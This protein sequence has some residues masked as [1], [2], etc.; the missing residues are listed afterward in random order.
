MGEQVKTTFRLARRRKIRR[1]F[2]C[3][4]LV[5]GILIGCCISG[6]VSA[7]KSFSRTNATAAT[8]PDP[9]PAASILLRNCESRRPAV[10]NIATTQVLE[11]KST[12]TKALMCCP[13]SLSRPESNEDD[14]PM[15]DFRP[16]LRRPAG[17]P[18]QPERTSFWRYR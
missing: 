15:Q 3:I 2:L 12:G 14:D 4:T 9:I 6:R 17:C 8:V 7:M 11:K 5:T 18:P 1:R 16:F 10:V 13:T